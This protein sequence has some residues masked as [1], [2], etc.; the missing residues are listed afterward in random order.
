MGVH[1][2]LAES[3]RGLAS[4]AITRETRTS[5]EGIS[6]DDSPDAGVKVCFGSCKHFCAQWGG[7]GGR[8]RTP[9]Q[10]EKCS[11]GQM[12]S[13]GFVQKACDVIHSLPELM[14]DA[15]AWR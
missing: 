10:R 5:C 1:A 9:L 13:L 12:E 2:D 6:R 3:G 7:V 11:L 8:D 15:E 4:S 14:F